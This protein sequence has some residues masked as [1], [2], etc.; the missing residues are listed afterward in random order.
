MFESAEIR[1]GQNRLNSSEKLVLSY[2]FVELL[3]DFTRKTEQILNKKCYCKKRSYY[4]FGSM[5]KFVC[6]IF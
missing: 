1:M 3:F 4:L 6:N 5:L 2:V